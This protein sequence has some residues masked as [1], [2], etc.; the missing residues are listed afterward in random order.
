MSEVPAK[1]GQKPSSDDKM[2]TKEEEALQAERAEK[3]PEDLE[4]E[5]LAN[6]KKKFGNAGKPGGSDF[7]RKKL[8]K[9]K[10]FDS[11]DY[12]MAKQTG[13]LKPGLRGNGKPPPLQTGATGQAHPT[14]ASM[15][16]RKVSSEV[17]KLAV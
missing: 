5:K 8:N 13:N 1:E 16:H 9:V 14:P 15:P 3:T 2:T 12:Q 17:S 7:L 10:Y 11:G 4:A 6:L